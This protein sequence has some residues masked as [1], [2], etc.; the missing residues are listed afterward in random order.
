[1]FKTDLMKDVVTLVAVLFVVHIIVL[2]I[3]S[4]LFN[5][6]LTK[7]DSDGPKER[8]NMIIRVDHLTGCEYF[9]SSKG[10]LTPRLSSDGTQVCRTQ[11]DEDNDD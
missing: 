2:V 10:G 3:S 4:V 1:M 8:S 5:L 9:E 6:G 7:D 11:K